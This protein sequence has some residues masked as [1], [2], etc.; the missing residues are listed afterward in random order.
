MATPDNSELSAKDRR[1]VRY[2][3]ILRTLLSL[4]GAFILGDMVVSVVQGSCSAPLVCSAA[5]LYLVFVVVPMAFVGLLGIMVF[6][7]KPEQAD[8]ESVQI[9]DAAIQW[10]R[11]PLRS[12]LSLTESGVHTPMRAHSR[13]PAI[14]VYVLIGGALVGFLSSIFRGEVRVVAGFPMAMLLGVTLTVVCMIA[15]CATKA[16]VK[17]IALCITALRP[18][19][20]GTKRM[21]SRDDAAVSD[22]P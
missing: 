4:S 7:Q 12:E 22:R 13:V 21:S 3:Q 11:R 20:P 17:L 1:S 10:I 14:V 18:E 8:M 9:I 15:W 6:E 19:R 5:F 2:Y 16:L